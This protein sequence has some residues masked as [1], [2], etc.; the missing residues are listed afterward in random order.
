MLGAKEINKHAISIVEE[1]VG[2][3]RRSS[4]EHTHGV[5]DVGSGVRGA[6]Q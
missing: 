4:T 3:E 5:G 1:L 2:G 6:V